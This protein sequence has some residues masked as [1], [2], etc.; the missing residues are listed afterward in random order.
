[1]VWTT[2]GGA[3]R[4]PWNSILNPAHAF[5]CTLCGLASLFPCFLCRTVTELVVARATRIVLERISLIRVS[6]SVTFQ[7]IL[8]YV[9]H[10]IEPDC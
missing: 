2:K 4:S 6:P 3:D 8:M 7:P 9:D 5:W 1:V 10:E